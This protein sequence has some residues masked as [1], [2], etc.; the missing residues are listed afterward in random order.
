MNELAAEL[1]TR[2]AFLQELIRSLLLVGVICL[3]GVGMEDVV[4][5]LRAVPT[6]SLSGHGYR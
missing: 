5:L 6:G 2:T 4:V 1:G 3:V